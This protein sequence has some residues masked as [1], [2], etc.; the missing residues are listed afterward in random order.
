MGPWPFVGGRIQRLLGPDYSF[1]AASRPESGS[2]AAGSLTVH[3][4]EQDQLIED[5]FAGL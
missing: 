4:Q 5:A 3:E 1:R 2:P